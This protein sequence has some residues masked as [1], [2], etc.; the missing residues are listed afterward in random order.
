M[1][2][3]DA[4]RSERNQDVKRAMDALRVAPR[5]SL[6]PSDIE[7]MKSLAQSRMKSLEGKGKKR[8]VR[9]A[10]RILLCATISVLVAG[11]LSFVASETLGVQWGAAWKNL[12]GSNLILAK[13]GDKTITQGDVDSYQFL[14]R[15]SR[16]MF[17]SETQ[18]EV[19]PPALKTARQIV[20]KAIINDLLD[21]EAEKRG[22]TVPDAQVQTFIDGQKKLL[23]A[24]DSEGTRNQKDFIAGAGYTIDQ[25]FR[26]LAPEYRRAILQGMLLRQA[27]AESQSTFDKVAYEKKLLDEYKDI[28]WV[29]ETLTGILS[30]D[31]KDLWTPNS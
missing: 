19:T 31:I 28:I 13:V 12:T 23:E 22:I 2:T 1:E 18:P 27:A 10:T 26:M 29:D 7:G 21:L 30:D 16:E 24:D 15:V 11:A 17:A 6:P 8:H 3:C 20:L 5:P 25:Y 9:T 14:D 4:H